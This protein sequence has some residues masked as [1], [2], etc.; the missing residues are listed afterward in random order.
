MAV[1][2]Q[3]LNGM[4]Q[5]VI[6]N[7]SDIFISFVKLVLLPSPRRRLV[8]ERKLGKYV[9]SEIT[10]VEIA[11]QEIAKCLLIMWRFMLLFGLRFGRVN[12]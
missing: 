9:H 8:G 7:G 3:Y 6:D 10:S 2:R 11:M 12:K 4:F 1:I 5:F